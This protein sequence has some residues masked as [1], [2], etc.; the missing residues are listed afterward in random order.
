MAKLAS[1]TGPM[2]GTLEVL[3]VRSP[4]WCGTAVAAAEVGGDEL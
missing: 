3:Q 1:L 4:G 2:C